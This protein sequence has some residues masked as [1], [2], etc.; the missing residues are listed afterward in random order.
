MAS[1]N[2]VVW[3]ICQYNA[4]LPW[5]LH[6]PAQN[7]CLTLEDAT[8]AINQTFPKINLSP[9]GVQEDVGSYKTL[10]TAA[11]SGAAVVS[12]PKPG[13]E[14]EWHAIISAP[15]SGAESVFQA[16]RRVFF[17]KITWKYKCL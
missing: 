15:F 1:L 7:F 4:C 2:N 16:L 5:H 6:T 17:S 11:P 10:L 3:A 13:S 8:E 14:S 9:L 12:K